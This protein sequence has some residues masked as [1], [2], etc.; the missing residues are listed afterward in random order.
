[1]GKMPHL[2]IFITKKFMYKKITKHSVFFY[3]Q[4]YVLSIQLLL[5]KEK[6]KIKFITVD[7]TTKLKRALS[8]Y[9]LQK[10]FIN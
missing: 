5:K 9:S 3:N 7:I 4:K 8:S 2:K 1:M 6:L 10:Y